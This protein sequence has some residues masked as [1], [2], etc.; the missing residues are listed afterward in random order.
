LKAL[1]SPYIL[2]GMKSKPDCIPCLFNQTLKTARICG[3]SEDQQ[4]EVLQKLIKRIVHLDMQNSP[5]INSM[6]AYEI[7][8]EM[9][10]IKDPYEKE[11]V[12]SN[13]L[14]LSMIP[15]LEEQLD[16]SAD[17]LKL[18]LHIAAAGNLIDY[19]ITDDFSNLENDLLKL[20][21]EGFALSHIEDFRKEIGPGKKLLYLADNAGE[22][23]L[24]TLL[25]KEILK[26]GTEVIVSVKSGP[27]INDACM[28]DAEVSGMTGLTKVIETGGADIGVNWNNISNEFSKSVESADI[29]ISKGQGNFETCSERE[30]NFYFL[31][32]AKC[33]MVAREMGVPFGRIAFRH[34]PEG[35]AIS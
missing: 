2:R 26:T 28:A 24:D 15:L 27:I 16:Q 3:C 19:G 23:V 5:A 9:T 25:V 10:G 33:N 7:I 34:S 20:I 1:A 21:H 17:R 18:A 14:A 8:S 32:K 13:E 29:I 31:L 6:P 4:T 11:K 12:A 22:I 30:D 35:S